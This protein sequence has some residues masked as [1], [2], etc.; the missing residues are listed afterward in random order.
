MLTDKNPWVDEAPSIDAFPTVK[1][2]AVPNVA[3]PPRQPIQPAFTRSGIPVPEHMLPVVEP[4][5]ANRIWIV[6]AHGGA[7]ESTL[8]ALDPTWEAANHAFPA[9]SQVIVCCRTDAAGLERGRLAL[10]QVMAGYAGAARV[11]ALALVSDSPARL[12]S[13]LK[14][15]RRL[16]ASLAPTVVDFPYQR[17]LRTTPVTTG[18]V[19]PGLFE[20][21]VSTLHH[22]LDLPISTQGV[23][24]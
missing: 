10:Q 15:R 8:A 17:Q 6:G 23:R 1:D 3:L 16:V 24:Q 9:E 4:W 19:R 13:S 20:E 7:G 2:Q 5:E 11:V 22:L 21:Q 14:Q 12:T 18:D